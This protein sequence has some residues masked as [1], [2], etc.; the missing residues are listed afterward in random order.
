MQKS[1]RVGEEE[2]NRLPD[3]LIKHKMKCCVFFFFFVKTPRR[4]LL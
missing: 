1:E 4:Y 2:G 3:T